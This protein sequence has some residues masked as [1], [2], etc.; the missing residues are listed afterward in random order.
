[1]HEYTRI[2]KINKNIYEYIRIYKNI[3]ESQKKYKIRIYII[4]EYINAHLLFQ[5]KRSIQ[6]FKTIKN[7]EEYTRIYKNM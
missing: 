6:I 4:Q 7:I 1:M 2:K 5:L 3:Q